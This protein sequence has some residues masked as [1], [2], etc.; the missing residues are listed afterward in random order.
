MTTATS[1]TIHIGTLGLDLYDPAAKQLVWRGSAEQDARPEGQTREAPEEPGEG[2]GQDAEELPAARRRRSRRGSPCSP[3]CRTGAAAHQR[4]P[5]VTVRA[6]STRWQAPADDGTDRLLPSRSRAVLRRRRCGGCRARSPLQEPAVL[7][8]GDRHRARRRRRTDAVSASVASRRSPADTRAGTH[9]AT[10]IAAR[11]PADSLRALDRIRSSRLT[12][13]P[14]VMAGDRPVVAITEADAR[15]EQ[16]ARAELAVAHLARVRQAVVDYRRGAEPRG[17]ARA[18]CATRRPPPWR[19]PRWSP[20]AVVADRWRSAAAAARTRGRGRVHGIQSVAIMRVE[21]VMGAIAPGAPPRHG[22]RAGRADLR[23]LELRARARFRTPA[24]S[25]TRLFD[26]ILE[27]L[28]ALGQA[29]VAQLPNLAVLAVL[30]FVFRVVLRVLRRRCSMLVERGAIRPSAG[31]SR[32]GLRPTYNIVRLVMI[33]FGVVVAYPYLP[34]SESAAF[35]GVSLFVGVLFSLG[36]TSAVANLDRGLPAHLSP[37]VQGGRPDPDR[38]RHRRRHRVTR[39]GHA[40]AV[41]EERGD[42]A[43]EFAD[44]QGAGDRTSAP[45]PARTASSSTR[46]VGIGYETPW[47]QVE[48]MLLAAAA[49]TPDILRVRPSRSSCSGRSATSP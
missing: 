12:G 29:A 47:R 5:L 48:A 27:P 39:P 18:A 7:D 1:S 41:A 20:G 3:V 28:A 8:A 26:V 15:L 16:I 22:H 30:F 25:R 43:P 17:T 42:R 40:A 33:A 24:V 4:F 6:G 11:P 32:S 31:S 34:G 14:W 38:R 9:S 10:R 45:T 46:S 23:V 37:R 2:D 35:K 44:P 19:L 13:S 36:S 49:R 21:R